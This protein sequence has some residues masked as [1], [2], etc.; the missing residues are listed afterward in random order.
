MIFFVMRFLAMLGIHV[1]C[2]FTYSSTRMLFAAITTLTMTIILGRS[3]I[4]MLYRL[5]VGHCVRVADCA[6]L[7]S[8]YQKSQDV[9]SID[10]KSVV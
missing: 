10:R 6:V 1:P 2:A 3:F 5:K 9:P 7:G 4:A 8:Q